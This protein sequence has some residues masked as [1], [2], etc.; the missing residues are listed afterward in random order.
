MCIGK[1]EENITRNIYDIDKT[2]F[3]IKDEASLNTLSEYVS[4]MKIKEGDYQYA[5]Y[6]LDK[7]DR[8]IPQT[9]LTDAQ[10]NEIKQL[11]NLE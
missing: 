7:E 2:I 6:T 8:I 3:T 11:L 1:L 5:I 9:V 10:F 4:T